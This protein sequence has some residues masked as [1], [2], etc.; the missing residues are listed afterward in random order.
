[1]PHTQ[2]L[3]ARF[4]QVKRARS[5]K[6]AVQALKVLISSSSLSA[7]AAFTSL[8]TINPQSS[9]ALAVCFPS[10]LFYARP[11][12]CTQRCAG[13]PGRGSNC[14]QTVCSGF[15]KLYSPLSSLIGAT[16]GRTYCL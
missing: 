5:H 4:S 6:Q 16:A 12:A 2:N 13:D 3:T 8:S 1:L 11:P 10:P 14:G 9:T 7:S 15:E